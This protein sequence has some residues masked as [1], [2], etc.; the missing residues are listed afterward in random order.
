[1]KQQEK[2]ENALRK[3]HVL[4]A[5]SEAVPGDDNKIIVDRHALFKALEEINRCMYDM[6]DEYEVTRQSHER[7]VRKSREQGEK[8]IEES[9]GV[10]EDIYAAAILYTDEALGN[11]FDSIKKTKEEINTLCIN[12]SNELDKRLKT[13]TENHNELKEQLIELTESDK[14]IKIIEEENKKR[15][16]DSEMSVEEQILERR[17]G[18]SFTNDI[19]WQ[20]QPVRIMA[21]A[22]E[23]KIDPA[24][25]TESFD[26]D[27]DTIYKE[28]S[29]DMGFG[30]LQNETGRGRIC[31]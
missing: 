14:Y 25:D 12:M 28:K 29:Q 22:P 19:A 20:Q 13:V 8:I 4:F 24:Y 3:I 17:L 23:I 21:P 30:I 18:S 10:A 16:P 2:I 31:G 15:R 5:Q 27:F 11:I 6:M 26:S 1:M 7:A 9:A